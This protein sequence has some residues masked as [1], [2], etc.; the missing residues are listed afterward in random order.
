MSEPKCHDGKLT[1]SSGP[2]GR[3]W[4]SRREILAGAG[5]ALL[6]DWAHAGD[7]API[8]LADMHFHLFFLGKRPARTQPLAANMAAGRATLVS[9]ALVGDMPWLTIT[10]G[11]IKPNG[12]PAKG[13]AT[14]W[15][16][17]E[18]GRVKQHLA[19]QK[20]SVVRTP[21]DVERALKGQPHVVLSAEGA[22]FA[23][24]GLSQLKAAYD[25]GLRHIQLVHFI[26][27]EIGDMQTARPKFGGLTDFG[28]SVVVE[29]NRLGILIDLAHCTDRA[30]EQV[31]ELSLSPVVWSH[32]S[33]QRRRPL[34][35]PLF[36]SWKLRQLPLDTA[37]AIAKRGGVIGLWALGADVGASVEAYTERIL[38]LADLIGE[39]HVAFGTDMN[40]LSKPA[41]AN[42][43]DLGRVVAVMQSR[44]TAD[45]RV[46]KIAIEN[47]ARVLTAAMRARAA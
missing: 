26:A 13:G 28:R 14:A 29:C 23:D 38:E 20:L 42:F 30:V 5:A 41:V 39:D 44:G 18:L 17:D 3:I 7:K 31:L 11:G 43:S 24:D 16:L 32:S 2:P 6:P 35:P 47:Y 4:L 15:L 19:E 46:R 40:A 10:G 21:A 37:K 34:F 25:L 9:W 22:T 36:N 8:Y 12:S 27:N 45:A 33:V 1:G